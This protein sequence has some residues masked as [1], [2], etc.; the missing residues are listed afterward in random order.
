MTA[1]VRLNRSQARLMVGQYDAA[2]QD[3][4]VVLSTHP[5]MLKGLFRAGRALYQLQRF[6]ESLFYL[7][8]LIAENSNI[9]GAQEELRK[10]RQRLHE[11]T[12]GSYNF[13]AMHEAVSF[14][15]PLLD[16]ATY[17]GPVE[18]RQTKFQGRGV[19]AT[20]AI[21]AGE[22]VLCE[23]AFSAVIVSERAPEALTTNIDINSNCI[24]IGAHSSVVADTVCKLRDNPS[25]APAFTNLYKG[26]YT[27]RKM[28]FV[29]GEPVV[30]TYVEHRDFYN[31]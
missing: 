19:F 10:V 13:K 8:M 12:T 1:A 6:S 11:S 28:N 20:R 7:E 27:P 26:D 14:K 22:L 15:S 24:S 3:C 30:D 9:K 29:D 23:K 17:V 2:L 18:V 5:Q 16:H 4:L 25:F 31:D 21:K